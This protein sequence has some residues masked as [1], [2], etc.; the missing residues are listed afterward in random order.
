MLSVFVQSKH[1]NLG[2][3]GDTMLCFYFSR[4]VDVASLAMCQVTS[5]AFLVSVRFLDTAQSR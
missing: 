3:L 4:V 5:G 1:E 2:I